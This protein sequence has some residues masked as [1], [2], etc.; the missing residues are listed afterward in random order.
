MFEDGQIEFENLAFKHY[1]F[2]PGANEKDK[3]KGESKAETKET[4]EEKTLF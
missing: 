3:K 1:I 4:V 2:E